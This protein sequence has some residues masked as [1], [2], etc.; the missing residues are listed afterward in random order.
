MR[1][2]ALAVIVAAGGLQAGP[3]ASADV[4]T[5]GFGPPVTLRT[6]SGSGF[7]GAPTRMCPSPDGSQLFVRFSERDRWGNET[8]RLFLVALRGQAPVTPLEAEPLWAQL[9]WSRKSGPE[10]PAVAGL[11]IKVETREDLVRTTNVPREGDIGQHGDPNAS[12]AEV[13]GKAAMASQKTYFEELRL[14]GQLIGKAVNRHVV[15]GATFGWAPAPLA[16]IAYVHEK[17]HLVVMDAEGRARQVPKTKKALLPAWSEDGSTLFY[18]EQKGGSK[19]E[20]RTV[21]VQWLVT[22]G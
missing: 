7:K 4:R 3:P 21:A 1:H 10:S 12:P 2:L 13:A 8:V 22:G 16:L 11:R 5:L 6:L 19:Y 20:V 14:H 15:P 18:L 9:C 17:G